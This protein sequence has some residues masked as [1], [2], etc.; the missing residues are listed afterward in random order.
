[1]TDF[2]RDPRS[3]LYLLTSNVLQDALQHLPLLLRAIVQPPRSI[4]RPA[5]SAATLLRLRTSTNLLPPPVPLPIRPRPPSGLRKFCLYMLFESPFILQSKRPT[6]RLFFLLQY[7]T[8]LLAQFASR[9]VELRNGTSL[10]PSVDP[11]L[12]FK[13]SLSLSLSA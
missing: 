4:A 1:M 10:S 3:D 13:L 5:L 7:F 9:L 11:A 8:K 12:V 6:N 2:E